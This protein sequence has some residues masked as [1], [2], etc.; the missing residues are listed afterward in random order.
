MRLEPYLFALGL[1]VGAEL[2]LA[3]V[4]GVRSFWDFALLFG[5][6]LLTNPPVNLLAELVESS[7]P[8]WTLPAVVLLEAA[9]VMTEWALYRRM[10][11]FRRLPPLVL[12]LIL[13]AASL[14]AGLV[15]TLYL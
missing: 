1:T 6:N 11:D 12:S 13:N 7:V 5:A 15:W 14:L 2:I 10:L 9:A 8:R 3:A 4:L